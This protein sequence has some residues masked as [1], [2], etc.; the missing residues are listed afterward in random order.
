[1]WE[2]ESKQTSETNFCIVRVPLW[3]MNK[4]GKAFTNMA[5]LPLRRENKKF[6]I[7]GGENAKMEINT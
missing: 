5:I 4:P 1:M 7:V 3:Q 2:K 6:S